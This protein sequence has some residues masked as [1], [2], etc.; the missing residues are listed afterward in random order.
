MSNGNS[1]LQL[2]FTDKQR[3][4]K[5]SK[6]LGHAK[7]VQEEQQFNLI[8]YLMILFCLNSQFLIVCF[9]VVDS[10]RLIDH[11]ILCYFLESSR[12]SKYKLHKQKNF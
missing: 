1:K 8:D 5:M 2:L 4:F 12:R 7:T 11:N 10:K 9:F 3:G 6:L